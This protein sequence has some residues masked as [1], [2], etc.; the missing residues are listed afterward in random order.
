MM[1]W[2]QS[3]RPGG[4][5]V[6]DDQLGV[7]DNNTI[8]NKLSHVL[9]HSERGFG[10]GAANARTEPVQPLQEAEFLL[11]L[12][13]LVLEFSQPLPQHLLVFRTPPPAL[14]EFRQVDRTDLVSI[15]EALHFTL[16]GVHLA[17]KPLP[18]ALLAALHCG[19]ATTFF[20]PC[21]QQRGI[22]EHR[23]HVRPHGLFHQCRR[24]TAPV[25]AP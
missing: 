8:D 2:L 23:L 10:Q 24:H 6:T 5:D 13:A 16:H 12:L 21:A 11:T 17:F 1:S 7:L 25:T 14:L 4:D 22:R 18:L 19:I 15:D 20:V 3:N 9:L